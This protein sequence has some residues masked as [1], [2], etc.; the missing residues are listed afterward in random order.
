MRLVATFLATFA[1]LALADAAT[2]WAGLQR[3]YQEV[4]P[5]TDT[6]SFWSLLRP[7]LYLAAAGTLSVGLGVWW[8]QR[9]D[10]SAVVDQ[11]SAF[12]SRY[13]RGRNL[14]GAVL[15]FLPLAVAFGRVLPVLSNLFLLGW[16]FSPWMACISWLA[17][18]FGMPP[19]K[20]LFLVQGLL[21]GLFAIPLTELI[22]R[23]LKPSLQPTA[24]RR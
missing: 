16:G 13:W 14:V 18:A 2:T 6:R 17:E 19:N 1:L 24:G 5:L 4:N 9:G 21:F 10:L 23:L 20:V 15:V 12:W 7:E 8:L 11:P 22:R 3:G